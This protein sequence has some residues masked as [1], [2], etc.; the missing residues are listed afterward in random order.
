M[1]PLF[2]GVFLRHGQTEYTETFP[3]LT[4]QGKR[5]IE[6]SARQMADLGITEKIHIFSSDKARTRGT[7][8]IIREI[9]HLQEEVQIESSLTA[10]QI[11]EPEKA[12]SLIQIMAENNG[13]KNIDKL[14]LRSDL[15]EDGICFESRT[16][17]KERFLFYLQ[18]FCMSIADGK[19]EKAYYIFVSHYELLI[20]LFQA[21]Y[22]ESFY[23]TATLRNGELFHISVFTTKSSGIFRIESRFRGKSGVGILMDGRLYPA[24]AQ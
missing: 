5:T 3:D 10:M 24:F 23:Q 12:Q 14:Y 19:V 11:F 9:L 22:P 21:L 6:H 8:E 17:I 2:S 7:A 15:F 16:A 20:H 18:N 4:D 1:P 13:T